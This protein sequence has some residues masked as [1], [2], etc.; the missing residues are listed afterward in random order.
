MLGV[1]SVKSR[2]VKMLG[3]RRRWAVRRIE[4]EWCS[5][6]QKERR[7]E[8]LS[9]GKDHRKE[10]RTIEQAWLGVIMRRQA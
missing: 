6:R 7:A 8:L 4:Q 5:D 9:K 1:A 3:L 2:E 10:V